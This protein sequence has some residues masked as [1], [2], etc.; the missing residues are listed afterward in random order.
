PGYRRKINACR[1]CRLSASRCISAVVEHYM[2]QVR[3][4]ERARSNQA[5]QAHDKGAVTIEHK[6]RFLMRLPGHAHR[7]PQSKAHRALHVEMLVARPMTG[8]LPRG[9]AGCRYGCK[10]AAMFYKLGYHLRSGRQ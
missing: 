9:V 3:S 8:K 6:D 7:D 2:H 10:L 4:P 5:A 1:R